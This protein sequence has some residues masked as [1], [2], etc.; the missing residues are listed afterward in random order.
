MG[1]SGHS[2]PLTR[3]ESPRSEA[4]VDRTLRSLLPGHIAK[5][6]PPGWGRTARQWLDFGADSLVEMHMPNT[7]PSDAPLDDLTFWFYTTV[8]WPSSLAHHW[9]RHVI[10]DEGRFTI[11]ELLQAH[12]YRL[13]PGD[14]LADVSTRFVTEGSRIAA[15]TAD[16]V[17]WQG[18]RM[19]TESDAALS[20]ETLALVRAVR[21]DGV[22]RC[23]ACWEAG[24]LAS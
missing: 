20:P 15:V 11:R 1:W 10:A 22:C 8:S 13:A 19:A 21:A 7:P 17:I 16:G 9:I 24:D 5:I 3:L 2:L 4:A 14:N 6:A 18:D 23:S 12:G